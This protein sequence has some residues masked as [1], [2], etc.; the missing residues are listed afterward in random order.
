MSVLLFFLLFKKVLNFLEG[1][2]AFGFEFEIVDVVVVN[3][4]WGL[5]EIALFK[6]LS[7]HTLSF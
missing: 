1:I 7:I 5:S 3:M 4:W 2:L 6:D